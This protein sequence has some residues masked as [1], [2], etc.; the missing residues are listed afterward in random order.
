MLQ[1]VSPSDGFTPIGSP[2]PILHRDDA[3][4]PLVEAPSLVRVPND[5][6]QGGWM[7]ILFFSSNCY[8]GGLY[9]TSY[10]ISMNGVSNGGQ[11]Y[12]KSG[13]PLL[14][15][16]TQGLYSPGG[17]DVSVGGGQVVFHADQGTTSDVRQM[18]T[19]TISVNGQVVSI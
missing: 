13:S 11:P 6:A 7:Y 3:D 12:A 17:L 16:G 15:T 9:D 18:Y 5:Q 19:G 10:A 14:V 4:G 8:S 2:L 1:E